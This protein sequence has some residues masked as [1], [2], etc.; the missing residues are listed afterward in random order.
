M[1]VSFNGFNEKALTFK[2]TNEIPALAP[3]KITAN[4]TVSLCN[5]GDEFVGIAISSDDENAAVQMSGYALMSYS[6]SAPAFGANY[7][8]CGANNAVK[9]SSEGTLCTVL[10]VDTASMTV[11]F[12]F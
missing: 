12:L 2:T 3:V 9:A 1:N 4:K 11:E 5:E 8:V 6:G 10:S 7:L